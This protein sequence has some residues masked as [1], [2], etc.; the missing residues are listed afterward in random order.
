MDSATLTLTIG[1]AA[2]N[3]EA[4]I[5]NI[6]K[7]L[8][9]QSGHAFNLHKIIIVS[10][11]STDQTNKIISSI[12]DKRIELIVNKKREGQIFAQN[13]IF[14]KADTDAVILFEADVLPQGTNF[15]SRLLKPYIQDNTIAYIQGN[16]KAIEQNSFI[17]NIVKKQRDIYH[18]WTMRIERLRNNYAS[19]RSGRFFAKNLYRTL[20]WPKGVPEDSYVMLWCKKNNFKTSFVPNALCIYKCP[21]NFSDF[22][23]AR[24]KILLGSRALKNFFSEEQIKTVY[25]RPFY[26]NVIIIVEFLFTRPDLA[27]SYFFILIKFKKRL[28][29]PNNFTDL[30]STGI[31]TKKLLEK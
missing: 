12:N 18:K 23:K 20:L 14:E 6:I 7:T 16:V 30:W 1:I 17:G 8:L 5:G 3:E 31:T 24:Q 9:N 2:Y 4:N 28:S 27:V 15:I 21:Q 25:N 11:A 26:L 19:G 29:H 10:D 13:L 22:F